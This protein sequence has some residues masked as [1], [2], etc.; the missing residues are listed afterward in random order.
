MFFGGVFSHAVSKRPKAGEFRV[1][2]RL[3]GMIA[4]TDPPPPLIEYAR[5]L[6]DAAAP[7]CLY[8]RVDVVAAADRFVLMEIELVEPSLY[9]LHD[10]PSARRLRARDRS[11]SRNRLRGWSGGRV[12]H[13]E[14]GPN[15]RVSHSARHSACHGQRT[16]WLSIDV[17]YSDLLSLAV[18][19]AIARRRRLRQLEPVRTHGCR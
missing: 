8:A 6:L 17:R 14:N 11:A 1:Q 2:E 15:S 4:H 7:G 3:G 13:R 12:R 5:E 18:I 10:P 19:A 9:L 16:S